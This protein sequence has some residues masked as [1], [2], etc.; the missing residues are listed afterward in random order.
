M[1]IKYEKCIIILR[2]AKDYILQYFKISVLKI[3]FNVSI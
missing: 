1:N 2:F 3:N